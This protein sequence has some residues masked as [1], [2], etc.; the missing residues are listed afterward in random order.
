MRNDFTNVEACS[1]GAVTQGSAVTE[2]AKEQLELESEEGTAI[3]SSITN[4]IANNI[5]DSDSADNQ[6]NASF[7]QKKLPELV[8]F[9]SGIQPF[10]PYK[11]LPNSQ[12]AY[13]RV[14]NTLK[15]AKGNPTAFV[16]PEAQN[17]EHTR[18]LPMSDGLT[19]RSEL[20]EGR[21]ALRSAI[22]MDSRLNFSSGIENGLRRSYK[23][24]TDNQAF[25]MDGR[26]YS[27]RHL[28]DNLCV[29]ESGYRCHPK[30]SLLQQFDHIAYRSPYPVYHGARNER[31]SLREGPTCD[32][33][34]RSSRGSQGN[35]F[36]YSTWQRAYYR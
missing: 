18:E 11:N 10:E 20:C 27:R 21:H 8:A 14:R 13:N 19:S 1:L 34:P 30:D 15:R 2:S 7:A 31:H 36:S 3:P 16:R 22:S 17:E 12:G 35:Y 28:R 6:R 33:Y 25:D 24:K 29:L 23:E 9:S 32:R 4:V 5:G 26:H